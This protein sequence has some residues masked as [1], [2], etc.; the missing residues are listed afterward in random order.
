[1]HKSSLFII[2]TLYNVGSWVW[3]MLVEILFVEAIVVGPWC[4]VDCTVCSYQA[5]LDVVWILIVG[6]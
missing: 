5:I 4:D 2:T 3:L 1:V 6:C